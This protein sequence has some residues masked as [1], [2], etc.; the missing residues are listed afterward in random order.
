MEV[1]LTLSLP[2]GR[3]YQILT[4]TR[5]TAR[6]EALT[7]GSRFSSEQLSNEVDSKTAFL[8]SVRTL[9]SRTVKHLALK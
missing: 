3:E 1:F 6:V 4:R 5:D 8:A 9:R 7:G 2:I